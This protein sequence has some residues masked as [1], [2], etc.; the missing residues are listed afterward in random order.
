MSSYEERNRSWPRSPEHPGATR[1]ASERGTVG[2]SCEHLF[3]TSQGSPYARFW[4]ALATGNL[5]IIRAAAAELPC[6]DLGDALSVCVAI[7][8]AEP[9]RF[10]RA[11]LR[12]LAR[13]CVE[14]PS[15]TVADVQA[16]AGAFERM[17]S[18]PSGALD[19]LR[20]LCG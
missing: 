12:W 10:E 18:D 5:L 7:R 4:R 19:A 13:F 1:G 14:R 11:A 16:A 2:S 8:E 9:E 17:G 20:G 6:V 15:A 3:V